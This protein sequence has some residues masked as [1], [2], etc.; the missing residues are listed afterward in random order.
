MSRSYEA[1]LRS[2]VPEW[3]KKKEAGLDPTFYG[4]LTY[5]G[6]CAVIDNVEKALLFLRTAEARTT[7]LEAVV[8][9]ARIV[10]ERCDPGTVCK[11]QLGMVLKA[12]DAKEGND[13]KQKE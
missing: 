1:I 7:E 8:K 9:I 12:L 4:T 5:E 11:R 10:A 13:D 3:A 6:D 2:I